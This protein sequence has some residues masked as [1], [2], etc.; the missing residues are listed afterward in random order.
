MAVTKPVNIAM[1]LALVPGL[2]PSASTISNGANA[3]ARPDHAM[4]TRLNTLC[5][6]NNAHNSAA[7]VIPAVPAFNILVFSILCGSRSWVSADEQLSISESA[8]DIVAAKIPARR[9]LAI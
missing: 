1:M 2:P 8:V 9:H 7:R 3:L 4:M 5:S 6:L